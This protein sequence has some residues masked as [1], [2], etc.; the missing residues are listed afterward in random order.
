LP[1][2]LHNPITVFESTK[3]E[4]TNIV[5]TDLKNKD[6]HNFVVAIRIRYDAKTRKN[7]AEINDIRN[8]YPKDN[9]GRVI[10]WINSSDNL[11]KWAD[12]EKALDFIQSQSP[13]GLEP[14]VRSRAILTVKEIKNFVNQT[15]SAKKIK[16]ITVQQTHVLASAIGMDVVLVNESEIK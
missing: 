14:D 2:A 7:Q 8:I 4:G 11:L 16:P 10:D 5:L 12:K 1:K 3:K 6:G 9:F 13:D 15:I